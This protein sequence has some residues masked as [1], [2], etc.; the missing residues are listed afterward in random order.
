L[1]KSPD[2]VIA[3]I[4]QPQSPD[5]A[6][7]ITQ[8]KQKLL[9]MKKLT[10]SALIAVTSAAAAA[11]AF[12]DPGLQAKPGTFDPDKTG[13]VTAQWINNIGLPDS[14]GSNFGL[15]MSKNGPTATNAAAGAAITGVD[16]ITL[17][18]L[19]FDFK[20]GGHCGAGAPRF[21]VQ[22]TDG[23][24]F[25]GGCSNSTQSAAAPG[26]IRTRIDPYNPGQAFPPLTP[27]AKVQTIT[28][29]FDE[30][31]DTATTGAGSII[32]DNIDVNGTLI[33]KP[34]SAK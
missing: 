31:T 33:G 6:A 8:R 23:F 26:W 25:M 29:I 10:L 5:C 16:G 2:Y 28:V 14:G 3:P 17:T 27:G 20:A 4:C 34:G 7:A 12:A 24:H 19:G 30:G 13:I 32:I 9:Q 11:S 15:A 1:L 21:N 18:E 22:A